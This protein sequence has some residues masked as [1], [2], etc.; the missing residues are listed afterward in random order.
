[1]GALTVAE[2]TCGR[3]VEVVHACAQPAHRNPQRFGAQ[4]REEDASHRRRDIHMTEPDVTTGVPL[5]AIL[6]PLLVG[7]AVY[8]WTALA[9]SA[10]F[11]KA[12]EEPFKAWVPF[13]NIYVLL[14][15][16]GYSG[17]FVLLILVPF[18]GQLALWIVLIMAYH[19]INTA[20]GLGTGM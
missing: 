11:R 16:G 3:I 2:G 19:R 4:E 6:L 9:L 13:L 15:L 5:I 14:H 1:V 18:V 10:V 8:V 20:F 17:W 12:G 7:L